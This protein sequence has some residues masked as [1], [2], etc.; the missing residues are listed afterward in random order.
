[1]NTDLWSRIEAFDLDQ[2][3]SEY[4]FS[5]R[6]AKEN[7]WTQGFV[8]KAI[9]EYKKFMYLA[10]TEQSMVSPSETVDRVWHQH[11]V[12]TK[13][14]ADFCEL[15]GKPIQHIPSTHNRQ[16][17]V[18]FKQAKERTQKLYEATF[19]KAPADVWE[20]HTMYDTLQLP[21]AGHKVRTGI[22]IGLVAVLI[23][24]APA[25]LV[26][27]PV[28]SNL[29]G[30]PFLSGILVLSVLAMI[31]LNFFNQQYLRALVNKF[32][33]GFIHDLYPAE[34]VYLKTGQVEDT[35][36]LAINRMVEQK[37]IEITDKKIQAPADVVAITPEEFTVL[38]T[39]QASG[40]TDY[41]TLL[42][43]LTSKEVFSNTAEVMGAL[44]KYV[45]KS[46][47]FVR[48]F[49]I[50][51]GVLMFVLLLGLVRLATGLLR[52]R[53]VELLVI[54]LAVVAVA[55]AF[56]LFTLTTILT[57]KILPR[58]YRLQFLPQMQKANSPDWQYFMMGGAALS[59]AFSPLVHQARPGGGGDT[60]DSSSSGDS[61]CGSS[62]SSCGGCGGD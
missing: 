49:H 55:I 45:V 3:L 4:G 18:R 26:L 10:A 50:N 30:T 47:A 16:D 60:G 42:N 52:G 27:M 38:D 35:V 36:H 25:Y 46:K 1:M 58:F 43:R 6:L 17:A 48:L 33:K 29:S 15:L 56:F 23:L 39:L 8:Q 9:L 40:P 2:P 12:F 13:S 59:L 32:H 62:C 5:T 11:L 22:L 34:L 21:K 14:Y 44:Q 51:Y 7:Y 20:Y 24:I 54:L 61:S 31:I 57:R 37:K 19:G 53:P 41:A 28:Y